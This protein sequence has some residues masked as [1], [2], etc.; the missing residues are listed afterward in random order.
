MLLSKLLNEEKLYG[1]IAI[2]PV[3]FVL[4]QLYPLCV[5]IVQNVYNYI[6]REIFYF[7]VMFDPFRG[8]INFLFL[9]KNALF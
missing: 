2:L 6:I 9:S 3:Y 8:I 5:N 4:E 1:T 7:S